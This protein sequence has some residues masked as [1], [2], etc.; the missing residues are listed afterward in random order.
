M[1]RDFYAALYYLKIDFKKMCDIHHDYY[2]VFCVNIC[3]ENASVPMN[4]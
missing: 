1:P 3:V 2:H 4:M